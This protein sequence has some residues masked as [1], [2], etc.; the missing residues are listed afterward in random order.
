MDEILARIGRIC[1]DAWM[2]GLERAFADELFPEVKAE[3]GASLPILRRHW[4]LDDPV[5]EVQTSPDN[6]IPPCA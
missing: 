3:Y 4:G 6:S 1:H 2:E 5:A